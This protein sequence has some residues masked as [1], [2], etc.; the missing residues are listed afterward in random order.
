[1]ELHALGDSRMP[2]IG[3]NASCTREVSFERLV[4]CLDDLRGGTRSYSATGTPCPATTPAR[5]N[6]SCVNG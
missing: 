1:M 4:R 6:P 3:I 2:A 5:A